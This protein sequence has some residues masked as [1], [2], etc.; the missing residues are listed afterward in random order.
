MRALLDR[1]SWDA[2]K[3]DN[4]ILFCL[5]AIWT[6]FLICVLSSIGTRP[7]T[8]RQRNFWIAVV[9]FLPVIGVLAYLPFA[10]KTEDY[11]DLAIWRKP[12]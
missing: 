7:F 3:F 2:I 9:V 6:V 5:I 4:Q 11:H 1:F 10:V 8:A 12:K